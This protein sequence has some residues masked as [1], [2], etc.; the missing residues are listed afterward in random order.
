MSSPKTAAEIHAANQRL[1][2]IMND[3]RV[4]GLELAAMTLAL[5]DPSRSAS[6]VIEM[7]AKVGKASG[8]NR[9]A[10]L[11]AAIDELNASSQTP[12]SSEQRTGLS[13]AVDEVVQEGAH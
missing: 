13:A 9:T 12:S 11:S 6:S 2:Q 10:G 5:E 4:L 7:V 3:R 1:R 8:L